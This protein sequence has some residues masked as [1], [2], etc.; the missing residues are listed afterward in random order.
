MPQPTPSDVHVNQPLTNISV[1]WIQ[2]QTQFIADKVFPIVP[3]QKQSD[4]FYTFSKEDFLRDE[5]K[6]RAPGTESA[7]GE[8]GLTTDS[9]GCTV[10]AFHKDVDDQLRANADSQLQLDRAA[11]EYV[12]QK[13]AIRRERRW[14]TTFFTTGVWGTD[15]TPSPLWSATSGTH[16][17]ADVEAGKMVIASTTGLK[18]NVLVL[19]PRV[20]SALRTAPE[21]KDAFKYTSSESIN[22]DMLAGFFDVDR[23]VVAGGVYTSTVEGNATQTTDFMAGKHALLAYSAPSPSI[24]QPT[25]GYTFAWSGLGGSIDGIRIKK[26]RQEQLSSDRIE[27]EMA[28]AMKKVSA[29]CGYFFGSAVS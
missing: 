6:P 8:F 28:Y 19:G 22:I 3:V 20:Y 15:S 29:V 16:I 4:L 11:T 14:L 5:A 12:S 21:V 1:A 10:E 26:F 18:P 13:M 27:S 9:Y 2:D 7:G 24:M 25:A 17:Q 23:I